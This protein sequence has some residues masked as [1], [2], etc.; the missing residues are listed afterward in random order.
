M[1]SPFELSLNEN[2][3][4]IKRMDEEFRKIKGISATYELGKFSY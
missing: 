1:I 2:A 3:E 4:S